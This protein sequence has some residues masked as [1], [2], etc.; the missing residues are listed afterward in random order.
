M[1]NKIII[2]IITFL[3][4]FAGAIIYLNQIFLPHK[5]KAIA[6]QKAEEFLNRKVSVDQFSYIPFKGLTV[7][8]LTISEKDDPS[9][10]FLTLERGSL[11]VL[12]LPLILS[13]KII[14]PSAVIEKISLHIIQH[15]GQSFNFSDLLVP[16]ASNKSN[17]KK[18]FVIAGLNISDSKIL[19]TDETSTE[20]FEE[21]ISS[22]NIKANISLSKGVT[23][24]LEGKMPRPKT[25]LNIKGSYNPL[26]KKMSAD[27]TTEESAECFSDIK[28]NPPQFGIRI[29]LR[30]IN[31]Q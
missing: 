1:R 12:I 21:E 6:I 24:S 5:L 18:N 17:S 13:K 8:N 2:G 31:L 23:F 4:L 27:I 19:Y 30:K 25:E 3:L 15:S 20:K 7:T 10:N 29:A 14:I 22:I 26:N 28:N 16:G 11:N 9:K